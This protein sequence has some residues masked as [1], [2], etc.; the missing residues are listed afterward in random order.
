MLNIRSAVIE[1]VPLLLAMLQVSSADQGFAG[2][3]A[4]NEDELREDGFGPR[5]R[6]TALMAEWQGVPAGMALYFFNYS[7]WG[8]RNGLYLEDLY[9]DARFRKKGIAKALMAHLA[10]IAVREGCGRFQWVVHCHNANAVALYGALGANRLEEW[11]L[12]SLKGDAILQLSR[13][14]PRTGP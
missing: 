6:F 3:V 10:R 14:V 4:V 13:T 9:V 11:R 1:D 2:E 12:M 8:S 7:T 5:P